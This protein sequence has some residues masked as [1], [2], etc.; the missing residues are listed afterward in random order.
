MSSR[1]YT[2]ARVRGRLEREARKMWHRRRGHG[3][4]AAEQSSAE[5]V[6]GL[7]RLAATAP[8]L[9]TGVGRS[10]TTA[11]AAA[12]M[13]HPAVY[14]GGPEVHEA[15]WTRDLGSLVYRFHDDDNPVGRDYY[16]GTLAV[17]L[18]DF[19]R[20]LRALAL[21]MGYGDTVQAGEPADPAAAPDPAW[22]RWV[23]KCPAD[24]RE[25][26]GL[27]HLFPHVRFLYIVRNGY[28]VIESHRRF[29]NFAHL[30]FEQICVR[31]AEGYDRF[32]YAPELERS[33][34]L[35]QEALVLDPAGMLGEV[36]DFL[37]LTNDPAPAQYAAS[38]LVHPLDEPTKRDVDVQQLL[39]EREPAWTAWTAEERATFRRI[40][41]PAM[42]SLGYPLDDA[43]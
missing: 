26:V 7:S 33:M 16:R 34:R 6:S 20:R 25:A 13:R 24:R 3:S 37:G 36:F 38:T 41:G 35:R 10:G 23:L 21:Q 2:P 1:R 43:G 12:L 8:V 42:D 14:D 11:L 22:Q 39:A 5:E 27:L 29:P 30:S 32:C 19:H 18:D 31:W 40:C 28:D 17:G 4:G 15:P 9:I